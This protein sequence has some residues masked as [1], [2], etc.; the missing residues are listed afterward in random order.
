MHPTV[1]LATACLIAIIAACGPSSPGT[2]DAPPPVP[3]GQLPET[4]EP[5][6]Y[7]LDLTIEPEKKDFGG[8]VEIDVDLKQSTRRFHIH[9]RDLKVESVTARL[10]DGRTVAGTYA[11]VHDTGVAEL[12]FEEDLPKGK[13]TLRFVYATPFE[14]TPDALTSQP[15]AA[16][17][18]PGPNSRKSRRAARSR[19][20]TNRASRPATTSPSRRPRTTP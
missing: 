15:T 10:P 11:Q 17:N 16:T 2:N 19:A 1:R 13:A 14:P 4:V 9:G 7:R 12:A 20:S 5:L 6:H 8:T 18:T 3:L